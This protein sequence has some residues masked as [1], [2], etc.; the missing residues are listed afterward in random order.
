MPSN[1]TPITIAGPDFVPNTETLAYTVAG[2]KLL[3]VRY[4]YLSY[5]GS[6]SDVAVGVGGTAADE[7]IIDYTF[8]TLTATS[9]WMYVPIPAAGTLY[10]SADQA[11]DA[12][13]V[14]TG[15]LYDA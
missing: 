2:G 3:V 5:D 12:V 13:M 1:R 4:A 7:R 11:S 9:F 10:W 8:E 15:D 14:I 6:G